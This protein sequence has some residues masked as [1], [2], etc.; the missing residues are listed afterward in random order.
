MST[1]I[2]KQFLIFQKKTGFVT[3]KNNTKNKRCP[4]NI[5]ICNDFRELYDN[6]KTFRS[7]FNI[8]IKQSVNSSI[9]IDSFDDNGNVYNFLKYTLENDDI[10]L[11]STERLFKI[12]DNIK[13]SLY[14]ISIASN[15]YDLDDNDYEFI[16]IWNN[17][18]AKILDKISKDSEEIQ[19][20]PSNG[21][22]NNKTR[23]TKTKKQKTRR[24][25]KAI[26]KTRRS[27]SFRKK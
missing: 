1:N 16:E 4:D 23:R 25:K 6:Y 20:A 3:E 12:L 8:Y 11:T 26:R 24:M 7:E 13:D 18:I 15:I 17:K 2:D 14:D 22:K 27:K 5:K 9:S 21:G 19:N 10:D